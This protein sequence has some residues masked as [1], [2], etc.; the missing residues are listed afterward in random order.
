MV[1]S[2]ECRK[3]FDEIP[4][5]KENKGYVEWEK[6][7]LEQVRD[8]DEGKLKNLIKRIE[9]ELRLMQCDSG[10]KDILKEFTPIISVILTV[11]ITI[12]IALTSSIY[13]IYPPNI[14]M[15]SVDE[16]AEI[17]GSSLFELYGEI[18]KFYIA[19]T[20]LYMLCI[21]ID[22]CIDRNRLLRRTRKKVYY[23]ELLEILKIEMTKR[24]N[25]GKEIG[26]NIRTQ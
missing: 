24:S 12:I 4:A 25:K 16:F 10:L 8:Y 23:E 15:Q 19:F 13:G 17:I 14:D 21:L 6:W 1:E 22:K 20:F 18:L 2:M 11:F 26:Q 9:I 5:G 7:V 3:R